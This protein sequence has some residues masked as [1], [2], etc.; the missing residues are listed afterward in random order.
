MRLFFIV[1]ISCILVLNV[2]HAQD[3]V[4]WSEIQNVSN[5]ASD[6]S[7][8]VGVLAD[9]SAVVC[10]GNNAKI[11]FSRQLDGE[12]T[13]AVEL[14]TGGVSPS[15]YSFG[16]LDMAVK[17]NSIYI[18]FEN[19]NSGIYIIRSLDG[20]ATF[21][22]PVNVVDPEPGK[23]T[24]LSSVAID[25]FGNPMVSVIYSNSNETN[26]QYIF[27]RSEDAGESF[28][29]PVIANT[30]SN[31]DLVCE[32]CPS[33]LYSYG[34]DVWLVFRNNDNNLRDIW[35][36]KSTDGGENFVLASD[37]DDTD[38]MINGCPI[39]GPKI[40]PFGMDSLI[41]FWHS[42]ADGNERVSIST[43]DQT[44]M[45]KG[46][47]Y[48][49][50]K[51][52]E[53]ATQINPSTASENGL[54][55][56][57]WQESGFTENGIDILFS[58]STSASS[59]LL[60]NISNLTESPGSQ[61]FPSLVLANG[62]FHLIFTSPT[63]I[64]YLTGSLPEIEA[65]QR[66]LVIL[67]AGSGTWCSSCPGTALGF[68]DLLAN[69]LP[70]GL[71]SYHVDD[72]YE[73]LDGV[74]RMDFYNVTSYPTTIIDGTTVHVG[75]DTEDSIFE[76][77]LP[78]VQ[79]RLAVLTGLTVE[80]V[81]PTASNNVFSVQVA[82]S[83]LSAPYENTTL[84]A[85]LVESH[86]AEEWEGLTELNE[87][88]RKMH[89]G[90]SGISLE[91]INEDGISVTVDFNLESTWDYSNL[92]LVVF[93]QDN[94]SGEIYNGAKLSLSATPLGLS[95][96]EVGVQISPSP[97]RDLILVSATEKI[98]SYALY[99]VAGKLCSRE[100]VLVNS[101]QIGMSHLPPGI[102]MLMLSTTDGYVS[103]KVVKE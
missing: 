65:V 81:N 61:K 18:V 59:D 57:A 25:D 53:G 2:A 6:K 42:G 74:N 38:W 94:D 52:N 60:M 79:E 13:D 51:Q 17:N 45:A 76:V 5:S 7:A 70:V 54:V 101:F 83:S 96:I 16:G 26:A 73:I 85:V 21:E 32:C 24:S 20:G 88:V 100:N 33:D 49:I 63:G 71:I 34:E 19:F 92:E 12:F 86:I 68:E 15:I 29:E 95:P 58:T 55:G 80:L 3:T 78:F 27:I 56:I 46:V 87:V 75:G 39:S 82:L 90:Y 9:G 91:A 103:R 31:G 30:P 1:I 44:T 64:Q 97:A 50:P 69:N 98:E 48:S 77:Y 35:V 66:N 8:L 67:E 40:T 11:Y 23:L 37:V 62:V 14:S 102:Y 28:S 43:L 4:V 41:T 99:D 22:E 93:V 47:E 10:W 36:S 89:N 84:Q 72:E